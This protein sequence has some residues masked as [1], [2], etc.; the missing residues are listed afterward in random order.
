MFKQDSILPYV[1]ILLAS[2]YPLFC[3]LARSPLLS[4]CI[5][6]HQ[7]QC[8]N[9]RAGTADACALSVTLSISDDVLYTDVESLSSPPRMQ[10]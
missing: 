2:H 7:N 4:S 8:E 6:I 5:D 10:M 3:L 9:R 1:P